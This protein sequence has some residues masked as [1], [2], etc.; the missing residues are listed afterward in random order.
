MKPCFR[1]ME[2][3]HFT[4]CVER[5]SYG[6]STIYTTEKCLEVVLPLRQANLSSAVGKEGS[7]HEYTVVQ[8]SPN[9]I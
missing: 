9:Y 2:A 5:F 3:C 8:L 4:I 7:F 1:H 6:T